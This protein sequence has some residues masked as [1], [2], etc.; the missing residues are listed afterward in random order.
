MEK[1]SD[2]SNERRIQ[3]SAPNPRIY[4]YEMPFDWYTWHLDQK[5]RHTRLHQIRINKMKYR[6]N[7]YTEEF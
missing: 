6:F 7:A 3:V 1:P 4:L 5:E 2:S